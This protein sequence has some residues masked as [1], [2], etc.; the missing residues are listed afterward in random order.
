MPK[1]KSD[2]N[3]QLTETT[4]KNDKKKHK[5]NP[6]P[7][8]NNSETTVTITAPSNANHD[9]LKYTEKDF[10]DLSKNEHAR[11]APNSKKI[12]H[13]VVIEQGDKTIALQ[14]ALPFKDNAE[15]PTV[16]PLIDIE[17]IEPFRGMHRYRAQ[18]PDGKTPMYSKRIY[19]GRKGDKNEEESFEIACFSPSPEEGKPPFWGSIRATPVFRDDLS[20][21]VKKDLEKDLK[22]MKRESKG[23]EE[24]LIDLASIPQRDL[25]KTRTPNQNTVMGESARDS[26]ENFFDTMVDELHPEMKQRLKRSFSADIKGHFTINNHRPEWLHAKGWSLMP[27]SMNPQTKDNLGAAPKWANTQMM[28]LERIIKWFAL[29]APESLLTIK[30]RF[31]MLL[32]SDLIQHIDFKVKV[33]IKEN[34]VELLQS[35]DPFQAHP[36]FAKASDLA[37]GA[38]ITHSILQG[39]APVSKQEVKGV[40]KTTATN[41]KIKEQQI[42]LKDELHSSSILN[43]TNPS[44]SFSGNTTQHASAFQPVKAGSKRKNDDATPQDLS[45][46]EKKAKTIAADSAATN[47]IQTNDSSNPLKVNLKRKRLDDQDVGGVTKPP[48]VK[49]AATRSK[50]PTQQQHDR[51]VVQIYADGFTPDYDNPWRDPETFSCTGSGSVIE[52]LGK[53]YI[54]TNAH[55]AQNQIFLQVRLAN[56]RLQKYEAKVKCVSYQCD[57]ALLEIDAPEFHEITE[58]VEIGDMVDLRQKVMVVG[59]PMGGTEISLSKGIVSRIQVDT[60]SVSGQNMLQA[61]VDAA[62]NPG[63]SGGPVFSGSKVV[64][65]AFQ[66]YGGHQ[67]L[68]YIIPAPVVRHFLTEAFSGNK[69][70]GFPT[71]PIITEELENPN[72]RAFYQLGKQTGVRILKADTLSD[73]YHKLKPDDIILAIDGLPVSNEGTVDYPGIKCID[74]CHVTQSKFIGDKVTLSILRK[75]AASNKAEKLDVDVVLDTILGETEKVPVAEHDKLPTFYINS[76]VCFVPLTRNYMEGEGGAF[77]EM[78]LVEENCTVPDAPKKNHDDQIVVINQILKC[79]ETRGYEKHINTIVKEINGRTINNLHEAIMALEGNTDERH[80]I[81]LASKSKIVIPNMSAEELSRLL[82]RN[83]ISRD[84]SID[85]GA[86]SD[87]S[88]GVASS[89]HKHNIGREDLYIE[90]FELTQLGMHAL[91]THMGYPNMTSGSI[92]NGKADLKLDLLNKQGFMPLLTDVGAGKVSGHWIML[93]RGAGNQYYLFDPLGQASGKGYHDILAAQLPKGAALSVLPNEGGLNRGLC[94]YWVASSGLRAHAALN[95]GASPDLKTLGQT[96]SDEMRAELSNNGYMNITNW[97]AAIAEKI[98]GEPSIQRIDAKDLRK[99]TQLKSQ[100]EKQASMASSLSS[101]SSL[102]GLFGQPQKES[103][104]EKLRF[105]R[106]RSDMESLE[107]QEEK[108]M[109]SA[110]RDVEDSLLSKDMLPGLKHF[111]QKIDEM[112]EYYKNHQE[113]DEDDDENYVNTSD[114]ESSDASMRSN[115]DEETDIDDEVSETE[116]EEVKAV[117]ATRSKLRRHDAMILN[118]GLFKLSFT[119]ESAPVNKNRSSLSK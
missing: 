32:D 77:E 2:A 88:E 69:Y 18:T 103:A 82:K 30:P 36:I 87:K 51:S 22:E 11:Y 95:Q 66:G 17:A 79:P 98:P 61:Q 81:T 101:K 92:Y 14:Y 25:L 3:D 119:D 37:Q 114:D 7:N 117:P 78:V 57:L 76:G 49:R 48:Q 31:D 5:P 113:S 84:R 107:E 58:P 21:N 91:F 104:Q 27:M 50:F 102:T 85:L 54:L 112:E 20:K 75:N 12:G 72:E 41:A 99:G 46:S 35:I 44:N 60:Y 9:K 83:H 93:I 68:G 73:A 94:G 97:L 59:F 65:V 16:R 23:D 28:V 40:K 15:T 52:H 67:G 39:I 1:R 53:K 106:K 24:L 29:N 10:S 111:R 86:K 55:V 89:A 33:Q 34:F 64:G 96:I 56:D 8:A 118:H 19:S 108:P 4:E 115:D 42:S 62:I 74:L 71:L 26:Y 6:N 47:N 100:E 80:V 13:A 38:G 110:K 109:S 116:V 90:E 63:N 105:K 45:T 70:R 43:Y